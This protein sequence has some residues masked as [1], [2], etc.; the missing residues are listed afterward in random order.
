MNY[1]NN[2]KLGLVTICSG[3]EFRKSTTRCEKNF[4]AI[5]IVHVFRQ[6]HAMSTRLVVV[7]Y[8]KSACWSSCLIMTIS[9][10]T[11]GRESINVEY[12]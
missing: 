4:R 10:V 1:C 2:C 6:F 5:Y 8:G 7:A 12:F 9:S 11:S 3:S